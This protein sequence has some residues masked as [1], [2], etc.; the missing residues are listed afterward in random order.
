MAQKTKVSYGQAL[1]AVGALTAGVV[2]FATSFSRL[3]EAQ[4]RADVANVTLQRSQQKLEKMQAAGKATAEQLA[5]AQEDVRVK[6]NLLAV[7]QDNLKDTYANFL[8]NIPSQ[9]VSFAVTGQVLM[10]ALTKANLQHAASWLAVR[11]GMLTTF[12][13][14]PGVL[15]LGAIL[16]V[17]VLV[18]LLTNNVG[19]L[20]DMFVSA[21]KAVFEF[22][23]VHLKPLADFIRWFIDNVVKPLSAWFGSLL[24]NDISATNN[25]FKSTEAILGSSMPAAVDKSTVSFGSLKIAT[26]EASDE[27]KIMHTW[28]GDIKIKSAETGVALDELS[29]KALKTSFAVGAVG[30][31]G[32]GGSGTSVAEAAELT[33]RYGVDIANTILAGRSAGNLGGIFVS[34]PSF[35]DLLRNPQGGGPGGHRILHKGGV[36][37]EDVLG[38]G[39]STGR[40]HLLA[41]NE[42]VTPGINIIITT[43]ARGVLTD[44]ETEVS[45]K[46]N[47]V[48]RSR[49]QVV[50]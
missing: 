30:A 3:D 31:R 8:A 42:I 1:A 9:M 2:G 23:D 10:G 44:V 15:I 7:Q 43:D 16:A 18:L 33:E 20:R 13:T 26:K 17:T 6:T 40:P 24:P 38:F 48:L 11:A 4:N 45:G 47:S 46:R 29:Q 22:L 49:R 34:R 50:R 14:P 28:M 5:L 19:G 21:G 39:M 35:S 32:Q 41:K 27:F 37:G 12:V 25:S 36:L